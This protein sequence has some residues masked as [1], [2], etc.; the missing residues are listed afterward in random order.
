M[1]GSTAI[2]KAIANA[3]HLTA[4]PV[5]WDP[6]LY[7]SRG[8]VPL[9]DSLFGEAIAALRTHLAL[10]T[11]NA[12]ELAFLTDL[13]ANTMPLAVIAGRALAARLD[14]AVLV[15]GGHLEGQ[16]D[17][18]VDAI[19]QPGG[20]IE[21]LPGPRVRDGHH[22]HGTGCALSA[23]IAA[24]LAQGRD[25]GEACRAAKAFVAERIAAPSHPG[26]G[27]ASVL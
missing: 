20:A 13:P 10:I 1:I 24:L 4:A 9:V 21:Y 23:A 15:K 2:A 7:P 6:V 3:L 25:L 18:A 14:A 17:E 16:G 11:P 27:A 22:V 12:R 8:D 26:R 19:V 5:V